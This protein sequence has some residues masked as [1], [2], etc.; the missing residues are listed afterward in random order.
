MTRKHYSVR[1]P[2]ALLRK[3]RR[4]AKHRGETVTSIIEAALARVV[5]EA[6]VP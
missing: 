6:G 4:I 2:V 3:L 5:Y 1:L